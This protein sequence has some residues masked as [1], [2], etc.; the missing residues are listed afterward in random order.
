MA[1]AL[2]RTEFTLTY[3]GEALRQNRMEVRELAPA[4]LAVGD[5]FREAHTALAGSESPLRLEIQ[6]FKPGSFTVSFLLDTLSNP[7]NAATLLLANLRTLNDVLDTVIKCLDII[8][9]LRGQDPSAAINS[10]GT[11]ISLPTPDGV[12]EISNIERGLIVKRTFR[13]AARDALR[14]ME[15]DTAEEVRIEVGDQPRFIATKEDLPAFTV[16]RGPEP[17]TTNEIEVVAQIVAPSF[18]RVEKWRLYFNDRTHWVAIEDVAFLDR[19]ERGEI[20]F[21]SRDVMRCRM[22]MEQ[23]ENED[24]TLSSVFTVLQVVRFTTQDLPS[25]LTID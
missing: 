14:P 13:R 12:V 18:R 20:R 3:D 17:I 7:D 9:R 4:L 15:T 5:L 10:G 24:G 22:R 23:Y 6:P 11:H 1:L 2:D 21:G 16:P 19:V 25:Q 8:K